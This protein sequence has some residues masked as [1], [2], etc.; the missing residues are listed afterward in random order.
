MSRFWLALAV[1][2]AA[3]VESAELR[4]YGKATSVS[5]PLYTGDGKHFVTNAVCVTGDVKL[6]K[7]GATSDGPC[8]VP[9]PGN[10]GHYFVSLKSADLAGQEL[11]ITFKNQA[12]LDGS[13]TVETYGD[14]RARHPFGVE[15][16]PEPEPE[17]EP[18][19]RAPVYF[20]TV[21]AV[22]FDP[23]T[24]SFQARVTNE[25]KASVTLIPS[26]L[27]IFWINGPLAGRSVPVVTAVR[28]GTSPR[29]EFTVPEMPSAPG[30]GDVFIVW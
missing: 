12:W 25:S 7:D 2:A 5:F 1:L 30:S 16:I 14:P 26:G 13:V 19:V 17:P 21:N 9:V 15:M 18:E 4:E 28:A 20:G 11:I 23:T 29:V 24:T 10:L 27:K 3:P 8:F 22:T 6:T